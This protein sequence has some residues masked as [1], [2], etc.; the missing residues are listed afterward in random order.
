[1]SEQKVSVLDMLL[2]YAVCTHA[3]ISMFQPPLGRISH[4]FPVIKGTTEQSLTVCH[5]QVFRVYLKHGWKLC[6]QK[7]FTVFSVFSFCCY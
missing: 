5:I 1:M 3:N 7:I 2:L 4:F 6:E